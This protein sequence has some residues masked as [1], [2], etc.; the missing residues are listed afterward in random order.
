MTKGVNENRE[1]IICNAKIMD[2]YEGVDR[3]EFVRV[4]LKNLYQV[5]HACSPAKLY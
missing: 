3:G 2:G 4:M 5:A 1:M